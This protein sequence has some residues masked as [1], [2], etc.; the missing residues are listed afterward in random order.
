VIA[1]PF[2]DSLPGAL[3]I[4]ATV[5]AAERRG[6]IYRFRVDAGDRPVSYGQAAIVIPDA[7]P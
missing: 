6:Y 4:E 2:A 5:L 1:L 7:G 3:Q